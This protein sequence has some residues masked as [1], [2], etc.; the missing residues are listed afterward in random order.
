MYKS[1]APPTP[2]A[3]A[4]APTEIKLDEAK[5]PAYNAFHP[6]DLDKSLDACTAFGDYVNSKWLAANEIPGDRTSW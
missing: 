1:H 6:T 3:A 5:L 4:P 2:A